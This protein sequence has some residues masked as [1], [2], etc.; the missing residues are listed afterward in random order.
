M[1][2]WLGIRQAG[3]V[4]VRG[5]FRRP[6]GVKCDKGT[7]VLPQVKIKGERLNRISFLYSEVESPLEKIPNGSIVQILSRAGKSLGWGMYN[8]HA[9][10]RL[11]VLSETPDIEVNDEFFTQRLETAFSLRKSLSISSTAY[12]VVNAEG[13]GLPGLVVDRFNDLF[14]IEY[15]A[16]GM[17]K[18]RRLIQAVIQRH[19]P[20]AVF[21]SFSQRH[22]QKQESFDHYEETI[23]EPREITENRIRFLVRPG[24]GHKTGFFL[25][26]RDN[27]KRFGEMASGK[28]VLD[29]CCHSGG[30]SIYALKNGA[31]SATAVD[32][33]PVAMEQAQENARINHVT[34]DFRAQ[35]IDWYLRENASERFEL[36]VLDPPKQTKSR[37]GLHGALQRYLDWNTRAL[38]MLSPGGRLVS[39]SCSGLVKD[40]AFRQLLNQAATRADRQIE[41][42]DW[43]SA[44]ADHP[45]APLAPETR[46]LKVGWIKV[47]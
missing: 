10:A 28:R 14:V 8:G 42:F 9:R 13:D 24:T 35:D 40:N 15:F 16:S 43:T 27:R 17:F 22:V 3:T 20:E 34:I 21:Y 19:F 4:A 38:K 23:P 25:D 11:R 47:D 2:S 32:R 18:R 33:D 6:S 45:V 41:I 31:L 1:P 12:R 26:Q 29:L 7:R 5:I 46:Y 37:E 39:C 30:F 44:G 36:I